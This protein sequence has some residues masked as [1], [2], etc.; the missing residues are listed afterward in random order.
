MSSGFVPL[1]GPVL[2]PVPARPARTR[3]T[4]AVAK[5]RPA[6]AQPLAWC[7]LLIAVLIEAA[8]QWRPQ[9][10]LL[11]PV[12]AT[13]LFK[14][15]T[16]YATLSLLAFAIAFGWIRRWPAMAGRGRRL[17]ELHELAGLAILVM[18]SLHAAGRPAGFLL[19][20]L[21]AM[22]IGLAAGALRAVGGT[23]LRREVAAGLL[24]LHI[25]LSFLVC[26]AALL[27]IWFVISYTA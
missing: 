21:H 20:L 17:R 14:T 11:H 22:A 10:L 6:H 13:V 2:A 26:A 23:R 8:L 4:R 3:R 18:L 7:V 27:H 1:A 15:V 25:S 9:A 5:T 19:Y 16:G 24:V 12:Q